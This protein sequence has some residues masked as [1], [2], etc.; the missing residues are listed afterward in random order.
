VGNEAQ[1]R[2]L[3]NSLPDV[4]DYPD[5]DVVTLFHEYVLSFRKRLEQERQAHE[6]TKKKY[7]SQLRKMQSL[8]QNQ[9]LQQEQS[10]R[11]DLVEKQVEIDALKNTLK[12]IQSMSKD[13][14]DGPK[15]DV[16]PL[17]SIEDGP[18]FVTWD[19]KEAMDLGYQN[20]EHLRNVATMYT[21]HAVQT[22]IFK[23]QALLGFYKQHNVVNEELSHTEQ[24]ER[25]VQQLQADL[26]KEKQVNA[27]LQ[28]KLSEAEKPKDSTT[29]DLKQAM[30]RQRQLK[31][32]IK[33]TQTDLKSI[34]Q[35][36]QAPRGSSEWEERL[37]KL[38]S[39]RKKRRV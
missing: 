21:R 34:E 5:S 19:D 22:A 30:M 29:D 11:R 25:Q 9:I 37:K 20:K 10:H 28:Q 27:S 2:E 4:S 38:R 3:K 18:A 24:L 7:E 12:D 26:E 17:K 6:E 35:L 15:S 36:E 14:P 33:E 16:D 8:H 23:R 13:S 1:T 32:M 39:R 31:N